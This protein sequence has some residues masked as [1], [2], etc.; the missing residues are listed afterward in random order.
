MAIIFV[1]DCPYEYRNESTQSPPSKAIEV[2]ESSAAHILQHA[3]QNIATVWRGD[4]HHAKSVLAA[5]KKRVRKIPKQYNDDPRNAFHQF[6]LAQ[7]QQSRLCNMLLVEIKAGFQLQLARAPNVYFALNDV[8]HIEN[9][10]SFLL[11]LNQLLGFI[12]AHQW[13]QTGLNIKHIGK[14]HVPFGVFSP[15]RGEYLELLWR[16]PLPENTQCAFDIGTGSGVIAALLARR[17]ITHIIATDTNPRAIAC[18]QANIN[19]LNLDKQISIL[20]Q[21]LFPEGK[22]NLIV[23]NPPWLPTKPTSSIETAL[24]DPKHT[25]LTNFLQKAGSHLHQNGEIWL[26]MSDLAEH[27]HLR[28]T[29]DLPQWF[30][31]ANLRIIATD[32]TTPHHN[33]AHHCCDPLAFARMRERTFLYRLTHQ[34]ITEK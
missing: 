26:I 2:Q 11:P 17:G 28:S 32:Y 3:H 23:C 14:I 33:K 22:A 18:A 7:S 9:N 34:F 25:M 5:I 13:H 10:T 27:L 19:R 16:T 30:Q 1:H 31:N 29:Q 4:F 12:G 15:L 20:N 8:Y 6:R 24:Y 21:D